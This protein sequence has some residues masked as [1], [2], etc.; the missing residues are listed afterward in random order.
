MSINMKNMKNMNMTKNTAS[1]SKEIAKRRLKNVLDAERNGLAQKD[2]DMIK[3]DLAQVLRSYFD[4]D[5]DR[6]IL[7]LEQRRNKE[8]S[9]EKV[10]TLSAAVRG[11]KKTGIKV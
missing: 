5:G 2:L 1:S 4:V 6:I 7:K 8:G 11:I 3:S 10:I 9:V